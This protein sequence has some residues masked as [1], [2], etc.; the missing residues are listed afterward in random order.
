M[1][2]ASG[3][4]KVMDFGLAKRLDA[5][6]AKETAFETASRLTK[7][8][9]LLGTPAYMSPEHMRGEAIDTRSDTFA[10]G[11]ILYEMLTGVHPFA[12][13]AAMDTIAAILSEDPAPMARHDES[14][15]G[16]PDL[17][18]EKMT[19]K[20]PDARYQSIGE[21]R[22]DL[23]RIQT[24]DARARWAGRRWPGRKPRRRPRRPPTLRTP[25]TSRSADLRPRG[26]APRSER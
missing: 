4:A 7:S 24:S 11:V 10:L 9:T 26:C 25:T 17:V 6:A 20:A 15:S 19:A 23:E 16:L 5:S 8:G 13:A 14:L 1:I 22:I 12:R 21:V 2:T 18:V 3:H